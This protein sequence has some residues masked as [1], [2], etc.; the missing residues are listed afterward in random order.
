MSQTM[1]NDDHKQKGMG[2]FAPAMRSNILRQLKNI[3]L[4]AFKPM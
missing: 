2:T 1:G 4:K 3:D